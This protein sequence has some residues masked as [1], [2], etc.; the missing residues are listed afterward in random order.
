MYFLGCCR[1]AVILNQSAEYFYLFHFHWK[2][3]NNF[4]IWSILF[5]FLFF[6]FVCTCVCL[7]PGLAGARTKRRYSSYYACRERERKETSC[8]VAGRDSRLER[9]R[10]NFIVGRLFTPAP[11]VFL[12]WERD[13]RKQKKERTK[14][15]RYVLMLSP[16]CTYTI[17]RR[18]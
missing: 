2:P 6:L 10:D 15:C 14:L 7:L 13:S 1:C 11:V 8:Q 5:F 17:L 12:M 4:N 9:E 18:T 3:P 16:A